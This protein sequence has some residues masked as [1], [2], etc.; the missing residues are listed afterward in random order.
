MG[1]NHQPVIV[2]FFVDFV[3]WWLD[4][5]LGRMLAQLALCNSEHF[6]PAEIFGWLFYCKG[7]TLIL[8]WLIFKPVLLDEFEMQPI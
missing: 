1:W 2:F 7:N 4:L 3:S 5:V 6:L 8:S